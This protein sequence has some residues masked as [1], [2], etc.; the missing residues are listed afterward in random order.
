MA[1]D[2]TSVSGLKGDG[3]G[4]LGFAYNNMWASYTLDFGSGVSKLTVG[5]AALYAGGSIEIHLGSPTGTL[6]GTLKDAVTGNWANYTA[7]ST[8]ISKITGVQ[9]VY[10]VVKGSVAG[11]CNFDWLQFS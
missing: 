8:A 11:I 3:S 2:Y 6:L 5:V 1:V 9:K 10:L 4:G 7:Q